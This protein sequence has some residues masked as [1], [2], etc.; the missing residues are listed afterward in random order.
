[1]MRLRRRNRDYHAV[2][3]SEA[4]QRVLRDL[5]RFCVLTAP[6]T[7]PNEAVFTMGMQRVFRRITAL[8][9]TREE[10]LLALATSQLED[11]HDD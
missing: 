3:A 5:H 10:V 11:D 6:S 2:F 7:D 8:S 4:G 1:M 9:S